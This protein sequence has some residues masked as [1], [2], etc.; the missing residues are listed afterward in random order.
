M[1][2]SAQLSKKYYLLTAGK[3]LWY[4]CLMF[5]SYLMLL[6]TLQYIPVR[7]DVA[8]LQIKG[9]VTGMLH[10]RLAF[11]AHVY[12]GMFVLLSGMLQFLPFVR[13]QFPVL[14]KW[15]GRIY[16][17]GII[18]V[19]GPSGLIMGYYANGGL[20]SQT[21]F[22][23]LA[24]LWITFTWKGVAAI[25]AGDIKNHKTWMHRSF[26]LTLSALSLRAWKWLLVFLFAPAPMDVYHIVSWLGWAGNLL[27][28]EM[29]IRTRFN[30]L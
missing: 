6:I 13:L 19:A 14:H 25:W 9:D 26:A 18:L 16:A 21:A 7:T 22:C 12:T 5:F 2:I 1:T 24:V 27:V 29:I 15:S 11:F 23:I 20:V 28:A 30:K 3:V 4:S 8:F 17:V 10:Y